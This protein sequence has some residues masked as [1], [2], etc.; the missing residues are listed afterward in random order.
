M[1][2]NRVIR[3]AVHGIA[4]I[5]PRFRDVLDTIELQRLRWI[6]Q[7]GLAYLVYPGAEHSRFAHA[8]GTYSVAS[9][10]FAHLRRLAEELVATSSPSSFDGDL[11][12]AFQTAALCHDLGH[13]AF[14]HVFEPEL[15]PEDSPQPGQ[16]PEGLR[17]H[18]QCT[19]LLLRDSESQI[20]KAIRGWCDVDAVIQLL[21]RRHWVAGLCQL[22]AG[23][24]DVDRWDYLLRD[25]RATGVRYGQYDLQWMIHSLLLRTTSGGQVVLALDSR[26]GVTALRQFLGARRYM[27]SQVYWH[28]TV[29]GAESMLRAIFAR[30]RDTERLGYDAE[31]ELVPRPLRRAVLE[32]LRPT[33]SDFLAT[34][35]AVILS[36]VRNWADSTRDPVLKYLCSSFLRRTLLKEIP[37]PE[38]VRAGTAELSPEVVES[39]R[40]AV[41][42]SVRISP[43]DA[44]NSEALDYLVLWDECQ[45]KPQN[46]DTIY[47]DVEG[48]LKRPSE[49]SL[50]EPDSQFADL[51]SGFT[52][53][54][55]FVPSE[56]REA[57]REVVPVGAQS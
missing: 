20:S 38:E 37:L 19:L 1:Q 6:R 22:L 28:S 36:A 50:R 43:R 4:E 48:Q 18:E 57:A 47:F 34:D 2:R 27:Y 16:P 31:R 51:L 23:E 40:D 35:D 44:I 54:R 30:A 13:T 32:Q 52:I 14:S 15:L 12:R 29:R 10:V 53:R 3:D 24:Y 25:A 5:E 7:T 33:V 46:L 39:V 45:W 9:R 49:L 41:R 55:L 42:R 26:R 11:L 17:K 21:D 8:L 56:A